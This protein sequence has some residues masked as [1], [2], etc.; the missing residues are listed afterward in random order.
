M[1]IENSTESDLDQQVLQ[2]VHKGLYNGIN[3]WT[4]IPASSHYDV[5]SVVTS[6]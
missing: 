6:S 1:Q 4:V 5:I 2:T 3:R